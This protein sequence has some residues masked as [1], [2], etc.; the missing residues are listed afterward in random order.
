MALFQCL[1]ALWLQLGPPGFPSLGLAFS[2]RIPTETSPADNPT[3]SPAFGRKQ[4][5][6]YVHRSRHRLVS[7]R[8]LLDWSRHGFHIHFGL[9]PISVWLH[10]GLTSKS[11]RSHVGLGSIPLRFHFDFIS[12]W[13]RI[14]FSLTS[15][16]H[17][18]HFDLSIAKSCKTSDTSC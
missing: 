9:T 15:V 1:H 10:F 16:S 3:H 2:F 8:R 18:F 11:L 14:H 5:T 17:R 4:E 13:L 12:V 7:P 6:L